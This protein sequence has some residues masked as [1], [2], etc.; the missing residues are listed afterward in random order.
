[1]AKNTNLRNA[2]KAKNDEFFTQL[3]DIE[4]EISHY[5]NAYFKGKV[6]LC[7]CNDG[8]D[9]KF[10]EYFHKNFKFK[11]LKKLIGISYALQ[12]DTENRGKVYIYEGG[13]TADSDMD[14]N[15]CVEKELRFEYL[16]RERIKRY[17]RF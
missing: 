12:E 17:R 2:K 8:T 5:D 15:I 13:T 14:L 9:S 7:N 10:W 16:C 4:R 6:V 3:S 11:G 1:M